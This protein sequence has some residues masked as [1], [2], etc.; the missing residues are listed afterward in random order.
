MSSNLG[1]TKR[2][3]ICQGFHFQKIKEN[4]ITKQLLMY[5]HEYYSSGPF[6]CVPGMHN[7]SFLPVL[8]LPFYPPMFT[9]SG[10]ETLKLFWT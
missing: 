2:Q 10:V 7:Y 8:S 6:E 4:P 1:D 3:Q 9:I 5:V